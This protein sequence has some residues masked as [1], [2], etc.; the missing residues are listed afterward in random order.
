MDEDIEED[1]VAPVEEREAHEVDGEEEG[2]EDVGGAMVE[3]GG[4]IRLEGQDEVGG[5]MDQVDPLSFPGEDTC[6]RPG[7]P[8]DKSS[9]S[10]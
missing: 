3:A 4:A 6:W 8:G 2:H 5:A 1:Q 10:E 9:W 7:G